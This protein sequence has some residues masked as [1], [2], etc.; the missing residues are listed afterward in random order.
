MT[1]KSFLSWIIVIPI[2]FIKST[3]VA[4]KTASIK[5][6]GLHA[7]LDAGISNGKCYK[8]LDNCNKHSFNGIIQCT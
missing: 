1:S 3:L 5:A 2:I 8:K 6:Y 4:K 7:F